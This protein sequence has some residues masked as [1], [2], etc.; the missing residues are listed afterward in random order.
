MPGHLSD[1]APLYFLN[2]LEN[3]GSA[4]ADVTGV[5]KNNNKAVHASGKLTVK[6]W[7]FTIKN[8]ARS[9]ADSFDF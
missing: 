1:L 7:F 3:D 4:L 8:W 9:L 2:N 5:V 6:K